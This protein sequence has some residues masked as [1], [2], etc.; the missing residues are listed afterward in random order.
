MGD[1]VEQFSE[2]C[3][4]VAHQQDVSITAKQESRPA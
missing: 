3:V 2:V 1:K 4:V